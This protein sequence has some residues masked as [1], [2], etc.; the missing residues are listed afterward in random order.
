MKLSQRAITDF[1]KM[2]SAHSGIGT[3]EDEADLMGNDLLQFIRLIY[4]QI[5]KEHYAEFKRLES[6]GK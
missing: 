6:E 4:R 3:S 1:Q 5:P 2:Y